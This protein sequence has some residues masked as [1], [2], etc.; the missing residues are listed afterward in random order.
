M[1]LAFD[2]ADV[3]PVSAAN[4]AVPMRI[5]L[6]HGHGLALYKGLDDNQIRA[7]E[8]EL[9]T[10]FADDAETRL[11]VALRFRALLHVFDARRLKLLFLMTGFKLISRA[12]AEAATQRLN[13]NYGFSAQRFVLALEAARP[14]EA[15]RYTIS[16]REAS[17]QIAA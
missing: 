14:A 7:I 10:H 6:E 17:N 1:T 2:A 4:L 13:T 11:A 16:V 12:L 15:P 3:P 9:W 8:T 5:A